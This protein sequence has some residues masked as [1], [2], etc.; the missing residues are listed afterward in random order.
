MIFILFRCPSGSFV[1][2][3][4]PVPGTPVT[5]IVLSQQFRPGTG[6]LQ[7]RLRRERIHRRRIRLRAESVEEL[8]ARV[9]ASRVEKGSATMSRNTQGKHL[10]GAKSL[11]VLTG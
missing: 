5:Q 4:L 11:A 9:A 8:D 10:V 6:E 2:L 3:P 1:C 7:G